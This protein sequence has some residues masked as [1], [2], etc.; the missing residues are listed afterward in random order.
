VNKPED[1]LSR[2]SCE[3]A[4][5]IAEAHLSCLDTA[6]HVHRSRE[7]I[8]RSLELLRNTPAKR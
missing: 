8:D 6:E 4:K 5:H 1:P 3:S 2:A 7:A